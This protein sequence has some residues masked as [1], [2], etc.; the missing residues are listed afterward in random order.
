M[1]GQVGS[2]CEVHYSASKAALIGMT[3]A[4]A[5]ELGP[6]GITVNCIA[7]GVINTDMNSALS[8]TDLAELCIETP[9]M[10][11]G[12]PNDVAEA[13]LFLASDKAGFITGAVINVNGGFVV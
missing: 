12:E 2:S 1:W 4:L 8:E 10:K 7:P 13:A 5:K 6:S 11:I 9:L 3:K